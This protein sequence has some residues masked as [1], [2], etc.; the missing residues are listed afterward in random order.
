HKEHWGFTENDHWNNQN[1]EKLQRTLQEFIHRNINN[2]YSETYRNQDAYFI[3]DSVSH[4]GVIIYRGGDKDYQLWS[5]WKLSDT[6]YNQVTQPPFKLCAVV[7]T[8]YEDILDGIA[9]SEVERDDLLKR[10]LKVYLHDKN[11]YSDE[12]YNQ[13]ADFFEL[14]ESYIPLSFE[15]RDEVTPEDNYELDYEK[16]KKKAKD[17]LGALEKLAI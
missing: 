17:I 9:N 4:N 7:L 16:I 10:F 5:G 15:G 2:V 8:V 12:V 13:I 11:S 6:Q 1:K 14:A 3:V